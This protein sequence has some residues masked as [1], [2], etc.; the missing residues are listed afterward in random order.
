[1]P[2]GV[3]SG[4]LA[5]LPWLHL[6]A[7]LPV[8]VRPIDVN[9]ASR[10]VL[11]AEL[12]LSAARVNRILRARARR[13]L[14]DARDLAAAARLSAREAAA[15]AD[16]V[17][18]LIRPEV[19]LLDA[20]I[21]RGRLFS[22][23]PW[24]V[25]V[26]FLPPTDGAVAVAS[27]EVRWRGRP[28]LLQR[29]VSAAESARGV[30]RLAA[31]RAH[32][33]PPGPVELLV[34][35][36]DTR[37]GA[38][39]HCREAWVLPSNPLTLFVSP[40]N[41]SIYNGSVRP[42]WQAPRWV[43][44]V[45]LTFVNGD[46]SRVV[47]QRP[48][49]W[50]FW[51]GGVGG[52]L[53]ESG[54]FTWPH[55][56]DIPAFGTYGGWMTF[57]SPPGSG[58]HGRY[59]NKEDMSIELI[60][61]PQAGGSIAGT[62]TCRVMAGWGVNIIEVGSYSSAEESAIAAGIDDARDVY[63]NHGLSFASVDWWIISN[64]EAGGY[65]ALDDEDEWEDLLDDWT[66]RNDSVDCFVVRGFWNSYAGYSPIPGPAT[67][68]DDDDG[69]AV[70]NG[71]GCMAHELG[72]YVGGHDHADALGRGNVMHSICGGRNFTYD[73]YRGFLG[74]GWTRILR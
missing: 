30:L 7:R 20:A 35:L 10:R 22:D 52:T 59:E 16:R 39:T 48:M 13:P 50:K 11:R 19:V 65:T 26:R 72:H 32:A 55:T 23:R 21:E 9:R 58:I 67:K 15:L 62:V 3:R 56:I 34:T 45:N 29:R 6:G 42:D 36:Y 54:S 61:Q 38:A 27:L 24:A 51:D 49:T 25:Q 66:V 47:L 40:A 5:T 12:G 53:V 1:M 69:L 2:T 63:E 43:T 60:F 68:D 18:G 14:R 17:V 31:G 74:H 46:A 28:F 57:D 70:D 44:A 37:G 4:K 41:R 71:L 33:L 73:Q 64:A 8:P